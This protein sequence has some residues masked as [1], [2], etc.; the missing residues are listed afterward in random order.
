[1]FVGVA[2]VGLPAWEPHP[3][4]WL[5]VGAIAAAYYVALTRLGP[6][7][8]PAGHAVASR[9]QYVSFGAG[10]AALWLASD[11]P[12]HELGERYLFSI[13]M[14]QHLTYSMVAAPLLILGTPAW[15]A[16][17]TLQR[18][19]LLGAMRYFA[20][21]LPAMVLFNLVLVATHIPAVVSAGLANG[22]VHFGLH[23]LILLSAIVVWM[24]LVSPLPEV[25]RLY[26]PLAMFYLFLQSVLPTVPA[27]FLSYGAHPLYRDYEGFARLWGI[28][29]SSDQNI[30]GIIMKTGAGVVLWGLI[31][32]V[33]FRWHD[34]EELSSRP[35]SRQVARQLD[36]DLLELDR[37]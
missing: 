12:I 7:Y 24:P 30:A 37:P 16:R 14:V 9:L 17:L 3:D 23:S 34:A 2:R 29:A 13:H 20:R 11:W 10:C 25:P 22:L 1:V 27:A 6:R 36:R 31:A 21:F 26:A 4:V 35:V 15:L 8:A 5:I 33:F 32:I 28:S 18:T 19:H